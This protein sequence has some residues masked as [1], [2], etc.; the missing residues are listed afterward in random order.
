MGFMKCPSDHAIY[1]KGKGAER[2]I[3]GVYLDDLIITG[4]SSSSI[5]TFKDQ[6]VVISK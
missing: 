3:V 1:C 5:N 6:M 4:S 2:L